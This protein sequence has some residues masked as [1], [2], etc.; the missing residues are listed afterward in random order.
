MP[1]AAL[2]I[3]INDLFKSYIPLAITIQKRVKQ[4]K[5]ARAVHNEPHEAFV[6]GINAAPGSGKSTLVYVCYVCMRV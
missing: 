2:H 4:H 5:A 6:L 1:L 3:E